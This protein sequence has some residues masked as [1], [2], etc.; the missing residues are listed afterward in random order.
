VTLGYK[1]KGYDKARALGGENWQLFA[2][3]AKKGLNETLGT[4]FGACG[5][6]QALC[7]STGRK[8]HLNRV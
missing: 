3:S 8:P 7:G 4:D 1:N 5:G 6:A 2:E